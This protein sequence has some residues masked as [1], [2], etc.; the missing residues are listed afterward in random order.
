MAFT[1]VLQPEYAYVLAAAVGIYLTNMFL[2]FTI[3]PARK[4]YG[5]TYPDMYGTRGDCIDAAGKFDEKRWKE[6]TE[7]N[8]VQRYVSLLMGDA[9]R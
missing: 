4:K 6:L 8:K 3:G 5:V 7:F 2:G 1:V 9:N